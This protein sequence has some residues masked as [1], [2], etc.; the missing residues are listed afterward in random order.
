LGFA[1]EQGELEG[2][3]G[4]PAAITGGKG[5]DV[6]AAAVDGVHPGEDALS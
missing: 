3:D 5:E 6:V 1:G 4:D 2:M